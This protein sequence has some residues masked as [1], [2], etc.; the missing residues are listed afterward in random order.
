MTPTGILVTGGAG[1]VGS[2]L[3][4]RARQAW[5]E[6]RVTAFDNLRRRGS[7]LNL[8]RL[9]EAGVQFV[10]GDIRSPADLAALAHGLD[11]LVECSAEP[12]VLAGYDGDPS[13]VVDTNLGG[14]VHCLELARRA[15][16]AVV[17]LSTSRVYPIATLN[18]IATTDGGT[19][20]EIAPVQTLPG[21][22]PAG[23]SEDFPLAGARSIYGATKL[24]SELLI[25]EYREAFGL[26]TLVNRCGVIAGPWQM[27]KVDQGVFSLW[28]SRHLA[29]GTLTYNGWSGEG[30]QVRDLLHVDDLADLVCTQVAGLDQ[31]DGE[32]FNVGGGL[33]CSLSLQ[34]TT[35][36][37]QELTGRRITISPVPDVRT[38]D[39]KL[40]VTDNARVTA[41]TGWAPRRSPATVLADIRDWMTAHAVDLRRA[42]V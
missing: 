7:E 18:A 39:V 29:G 9:R 15:G 30:K 38:A 22:S 40:Y 16:A 34:E 20:C 5:P 13:Y 8:P 12:S 1:F 28:M 10:H 11:L 3:A 35:R 42:G 19:R 25:T 26:R 17:F 37:C 2:A 27:G 41:A 33:G 32:T 31:F 6:A 23:I 36:L 24:A 21:V 14:T 4:L